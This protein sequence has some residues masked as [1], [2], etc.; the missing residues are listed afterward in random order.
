MNGGRVLPS[1][2]AASTE[3]LADPQARAVLTAMGAAAGALLAVSL[4][5]WGLELLQLHR[6]G[7]LDRARWRGMGT[8]LFCS[9]PFTLA[10]AATA[11]ALGAGLAAVGA[12]AP[13]AWPVTPLTALIAVLLAD[14]A[15][16]WDHRIS[17]R[18]GA[19]WAWYHGVHHSAPHYD[20]T[21]AGR[22]SFVEHVLNLPNLTFMSLQ[23]LLG[24][25]P[26]LIVAAAGLVLAW[27]Q[28]IHTETVGRLPWLDG[29]LNTPSNHRV[30]HGSNA[31]YLDA[32]YG[33]VLMIWDRVF[34]TYIPET[35][36]VRYGLVHPLGSDAPGQVHFGLVPRWWAHVHAAAGPVDALRRALAPPER[37]EGG[38]TAPAAQVAP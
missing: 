32:N 18:V 14:F 5:L 2:L 27:Q 11:G 24:L 17:H 1:P 10:Q 7:R 34:G 26:A 20:Q 4:P 22:I 29:W 8:S 15:F 35:E 33:G 31:A 16:Y 28:W 3:A 37:W 38:A 9:L 25:H 23:A 36:P 6:A 30:H 21:V 19:A 13:T 12:L